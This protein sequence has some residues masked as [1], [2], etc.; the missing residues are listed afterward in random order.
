MLCA[1]PKS[2]GSPSDTK[3]IMSQDPTHKAPNQYLAQVI[4]DDVIPDQGDK[5][6]V[7]FQKK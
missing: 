7:L 5:K 2:T 3:V 4:S 1:L 6:R